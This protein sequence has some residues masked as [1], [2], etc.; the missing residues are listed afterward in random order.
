[1]EE[2]NSQLLSFRVRFSGQKRTRRV[3]HSG[4]GVNSRTGMLF[5][6]EEGM[7]FQTKSGL[8]YSVSERGVVCSR[9]FQ[10]GGGL[11]YSRQVMDISMIFERE[12]GVEYSRLEVDSRTV[13]QRVVCGLWYSR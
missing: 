10:R 6:G 7:V 1:M 2:S 4:Q 13:F 12:G 3:W 8:Q 9:V 11:W 5:Q